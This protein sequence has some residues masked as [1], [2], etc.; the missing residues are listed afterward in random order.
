MAL[1]LAAALV[2]CAP[3]SHAQAAS[4]TTPL[5]P[6]GLGRLTQDQIS[7]TLQ[8]GDLQVRFLPLN[9]FLLRLLAPD[10][11]ASLSAIVRSRRAAID[12]AAQQNGIATPGLALVTFFA[13]RANVTFQ[14]QDL[15]FT[16]RNQV[17]RPV[18]IIPYSTNFGSQQ[19]QTRGQSTAIYLYELPVPIFE[20]FQLGYEGV[21]SD[22]WAGALPTIERE[23]DRVVLRWRQQTPDSTRR[24]Q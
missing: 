5:P 1:A 8:S 3:A 21:V 10:G 12:T 22:G 16:V 17:Y 13:T 14:P 11:Y 4:D 9:E 6:A 15:T 24:P 7:V 23:R 20:Q 18:A 2:G 19:L